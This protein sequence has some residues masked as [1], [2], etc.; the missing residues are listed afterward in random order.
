MN[1]KTLCIKVPEKTYEDLKTESKKIGNSMG[2]I[3][4]TVLSEHFD[5]VKRT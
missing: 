5:N 1:N 3:I 4:R 2:A